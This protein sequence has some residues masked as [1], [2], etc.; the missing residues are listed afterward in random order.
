MVTRKN[1]EITA[2]GIGIDDYLAGYAAGLGAMARAYVRQAARPRGK[3]ARAAASSK[4]STRTTGEPA[5]PTIRRGSRGVP[6]PAP[7]EEVIEKEMARMLTLAD[8][9][10]GA[11]VRSWQR[12]QVAMR[13]Q[14]RSRPQ[15][16]APKPT[17]KE[18][19]AGSASSEVILRWELDRAAIA[20]GLAT[21]AKLAGELV[22]QGTE[23]PSERERGLAGRLKMSRCRQVL[24]TVGDRVGRQAAALGALLEAEG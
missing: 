6:L 2:I 17:G 23:L 1:E 18:K 8:R 14:A 21:L 12:A 24:A 16:A 11:L 9:V 5:A 19:A 3:A 22:T 13:Q 4:T 7:V 20:T 15:P 10:I